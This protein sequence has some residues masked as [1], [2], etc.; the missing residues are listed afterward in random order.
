[1]S[2]SGIEH[3]REALG[4]HASPPP[5]QGELVVCHQDLHRGNVL[6]AQREPWL[7]IE[8]K[9]VVAEREFDTATLIRDGP[10]DLRWRLNFLAAELD[11]DRERAR[12][13]ALAHTLAWAFDETDP[14]YDH[15]EVARGLLRL[16]P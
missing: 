7:A 10:G 1:V 2:W 4:E 15:V 11:L 9:P 16:P 13:W 8:P 14:A 5:T 6:Q 3:F 12:R